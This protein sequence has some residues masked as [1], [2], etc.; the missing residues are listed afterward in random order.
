MQIPR[1]IA[2]PDR[3]NATRAARLRDGLSWAAARPGVPAASTVPANDLV[4]GVVNI[5]VLL[6]WCRVCLGGEARM[7][8]GSQ[9]ILRAFSEPGGLHRLWTE[10]AVR[11]SFARRVNASPRSR[12]CPLSSGPAISRGGLRRRGDV[13]TVSALTP[14]NVNSE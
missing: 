3:T 10:P 7:R 4:I 6:V 14:R 12:R 2:K 9:G 5:L 8:R 11:N 1:V 13:P